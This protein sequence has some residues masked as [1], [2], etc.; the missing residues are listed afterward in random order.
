MNKE[1]QLQLL[2]YLDRNLSKELK[3]GLAALGDSGTRDLLDVIADW[4]ILRD[5]GDVHRSEDTN[6]FMS[7]LKKL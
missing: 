5:Q 2:G 3:A 6:D 1:I 4:V 7:D